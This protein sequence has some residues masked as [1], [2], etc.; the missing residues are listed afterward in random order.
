MTKHIPIEKLTIAQAGELLRTSFE[1]ARRYNMETRQMEQVVA[2]VIDAGIAAGNYDQLRQALWYMA[3]RTK[4]AN[5]RI[6]AALFA[7]KRISGI[8]INLAD[9]LRAR[10]AEKAKVRREARLKRAK[11]N[12]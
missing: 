8:D 1:L 10:S 9:E 12:S 2:D 6:W 5:K 11:S 3:E 4:K 7:L